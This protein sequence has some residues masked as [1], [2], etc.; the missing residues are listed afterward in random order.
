MC[1]SR[2]N[3]ECRFTSSRSASDMIVVVGSGEEG[4]ESVGRWGRRFNQA[5]GQSGCGPCWLGC[6]DAGACRQHWTCR[7]VQRVRKL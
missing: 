2:G 7:A 1:F 4:L 3:G 5:P 6:S